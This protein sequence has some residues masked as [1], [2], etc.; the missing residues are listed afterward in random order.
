MPMTPNN[1]HTHLPCTPSCMPSPCS[2]PT[3]HPTAPTPTSLA[4][5]AAYPAHAA[6]SHNTRQRPHL[7]ALHTQLHTQPVQHAHTTPDSAHTYQPCTPSCMPSPCSMPTQHPTAP[8][9]TS[10]AHPAACPAHAASSRCHCR[11]P[12]HQPAGHSCTA[13]VVAA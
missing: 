4:H 9:P 8:T 6:C 13:A 7:P 11:H 3:Q 12:N 10:L 1:S 2:M 5:P